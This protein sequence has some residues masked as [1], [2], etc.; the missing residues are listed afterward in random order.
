MACASRPTVALLQTSAI[1]A[2]DTYKGGVWL[3]VAGALE[4]RLFGSN[5]FN[6]QRDL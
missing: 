1:S 3:R 5:A 6:L 4:E 2:D